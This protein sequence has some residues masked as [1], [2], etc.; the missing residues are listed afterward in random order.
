MDLFHS[1]NALKSRLG[2]VLGRLWCLL[3]DLGTTSR[4]L[5]GSVKL[6]E[7]Q[8]ARRRMPWTRLRNVL[9]KFGHGFSTVTVPGAR[10]GFSLP[11]QENL[12]IFPSRPR[13]VEDFPFQALENRGFQGFSVPGQGIKDFPVGGTDFPF[14]TREYKH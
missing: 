13:K 11:G 6:L 7:R 12:P 4:R 8:V 3:R 9:N 5:G 2:G 14:Q 1:Q 10:R